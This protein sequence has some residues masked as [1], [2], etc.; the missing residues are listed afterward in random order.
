[1]SIGQASQRS[2]LSVHA[3][4]FYEREGLLANPVHR[5]AD[6]RRSYGADDLDWLDLVVK[7]RSSGMPVAAIR[8]YTDLV[9]AGAGNEA[10]RLIIM[11]EHQERLCGQIAGLTDCLKMVTFKVGLYEDSLTA[12]TADPIWTPP[13]T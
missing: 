10:D 4:R 6:G 7:L 1:M 5:G 11:R 9:R 13:G 2:G 12:G 3:L 8:R